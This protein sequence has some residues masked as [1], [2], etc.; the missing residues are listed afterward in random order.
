LTLLGFHATLAEMRGSIGR[1]IS[2][3]AVLMA[4]LIASQA[5]LF[6]VHEAKH[7]AEA[8]H[9]QNVSIEQAGCQICTALHAPAHAGAAVPPVEVSR[10]PEILGL[11]IA[12]VAASS[13]IPSFTDARAPPRLT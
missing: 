1:F 12:Y 4:T 10:A 5:F 2:T 11:E 8:A 9:Q 7:I 3:F 6:S 13:F